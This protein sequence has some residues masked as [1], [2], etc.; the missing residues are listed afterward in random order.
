[1]PPRPAARAVRPRGRATPF[2]SLSLRAVRKFDAASRDATADF[3]DHALWTH[4]RAEQLGV[5]ALDPRGH[6]IGLNYWDG[7]LKNYVPMD[8]YKQTIVG[9]MLDY[10]WADEPGDEAD[11]CIFIDPNSS[12]QFLLDDVI[13]VM[14]S[15]EK[16]DLQRVDG[17]LCVECEITPDEVFY[18][19]G[20]FTRR[21]HVSQN[22]GKT[23]GLYG[24]W[25]RDGGHGGRPEIHPC[26]IIWWRD[27]VNS[28]AKWTFLVVQDD[29]NRYD[30]KS[31]F[32]GSIEY[33]WSAPP[34]QAAIAV[35][36]ELTRGFRH[37]YRLSVRRHRNMAVLQP[38]VATTDPDDYVL[39]GTVAPSGRR[40][41]GP[42]IPGAQVETLSLEVEKRIERQ[43]DLG[44]GDTRGAMQSSTRTIPPVPDTTSPGMLDAT[45]S[46]IVA[47]PQR[48]GVFRAFLTFQVQVG[49]TNDRGGEG[50][51]EIALEELP[52]T[53][54]GGVVLD[55]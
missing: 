4:A 38:P 25:V 17:T 28:R 35:A 54:I 39:K 51:A 21:T 43:R 36:L 33:P 20:Y 9:R 50:Y 19:N 16:G 14:T 29:S 1:M 53:S 47:D 15:G 22:I 52:R 55:R 26:E 11:W 30:R 44:P 31:E 46:S 8:R 18:D 5:I 3:F 32:S 34:R 37:K 7:I 13:Q 40:R 48:S 12:Y 42:V 6:K 45:L 23:L 49:T 10:H 24:P 27:A 41:P 2:Q